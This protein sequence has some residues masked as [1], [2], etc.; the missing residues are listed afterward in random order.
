MSSIDCIERGHLLIPSLVRNNQTGWVVLM[1]A[2][3]N[4]SSHDKMKM[5]HSA[6]FHKLWLPHWAVNAELCQVQLIIPIYFFVLA[7]MSMLLTG[8]DF[9]FHMF[10]LLKY[11]KALEE[12]ELNSAVSSSS[13]R[14]FQHKFPVV[15]MDW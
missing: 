6:C 2:Y 4:S 3:Q 13:E 8:L 12:G 7:D 5:L 15:K 11:S 1:W 10:F 14:G 9:V